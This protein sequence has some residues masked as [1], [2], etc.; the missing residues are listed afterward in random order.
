MNGHHDAAASAG[1][2]HVREQTGGVEATDALVDDGLIKRTAAGEVGANG[3]RV[4][5]LV[6]ANRDAAALR[7]G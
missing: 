1:D 2:L 7:I 4:D 5:A 3:L 6:A